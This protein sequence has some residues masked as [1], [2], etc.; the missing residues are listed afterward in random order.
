MRRS[1]TSLRVL[2]CPPGPARGEGPGCPHWSSF[3]TVGS[4]HGDH[5]HTPAGR[6]QSSAPGMA[7]RTFAG[8][9]G[10]FELQLGPELA[11]QRVTPQQGVA[12]VALVPHET[13]WKSQDNTTELSFQGSQRGRVARASHPE[14]QSRRGHPEPAS[15]C[16]P[17]AQ[18]AP[19]LALGS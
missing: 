15:V 3:P 7:G 6:G 9:E 17:S 16:F 1:K 12:R 10:P 13:A 18:K 8:W 2:V 5:R 4:Q 19:F 11:R 14:S